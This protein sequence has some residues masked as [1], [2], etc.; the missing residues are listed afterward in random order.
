MRNFR[1]NEKGKKKERKGTDYVEKTAEKE[2]KR[3]FK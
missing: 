3:N 2:I 1:E